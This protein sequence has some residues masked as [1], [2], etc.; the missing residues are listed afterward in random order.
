MDREATPWFFVEEL[1]GYFQAWTTEFMQLLTSLVM[2]SSWTE[3]GPATY[4]CLIYLDSLFVI[5]RIKYVPSLHGN[6][7]LESSTV[8]WPFKTTRSR[9]NKKNERLFWETG[10]QRNPA[11]FNK[12]NAQDGRTVTKRW[13][14]IFCNVTRQVLFLLSWLGWMWREAQINH[15][16][17]QRKRR[18]RERVIS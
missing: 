12:F 1:V 5:K 2:V 14:H 8:F 16:L 18:R 13:L 11:Q 3:T 9:W 10:N 15:N 17:I 4:Y 7:K 6:L